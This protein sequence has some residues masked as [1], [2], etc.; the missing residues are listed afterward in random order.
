[1]SML[2]IVNKSPF[3][4]NALASC[5]SH[6]SEGDAVL[7]IEDAVIGAVVGS[8]SATLL[9]SALTTKAVYVL[10]E[11]L[12]ARGIEPSRLVQGLQ[13]VDYSGFVDLTVQHDKNQ[14][15]L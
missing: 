8:Q 7:L 15:W 9:T 11:D 2:H 3:E 1:M 6:T 10:G 4:R 14:S 5:L 12:T 13:V